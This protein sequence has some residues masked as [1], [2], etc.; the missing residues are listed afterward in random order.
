MRK[1]FIFAL[2]AAMTLSLAACTNND[3]ADIIGG[4][5]RTWGPELD[6]DGTA[7]GAQT[8]NPFTE[9]ASLADAIEAAGFDINVPDSMDGY[10]Y[11][12]IQTAI[13]DTESSMTDS[14][15]ELENNTIHALIEVIYNNDDTEI[16]NEIRIRKADGSGDISGDYNEY[17]QINTVTVGDTQVTMK[18][19]NDQIHLATWEKDGYTY[20]I[21]A[22]SESGISAAAMNELIS[23]VH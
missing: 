3:Q 7:I 19:D 12:I 23:S 10:S 4:D 22:Y 8:A 13:F 11:R 14:D 5:P 16:E 20:S 9:Y 18:G 17:A 2:S 1:L 6:T 21:G 15:A